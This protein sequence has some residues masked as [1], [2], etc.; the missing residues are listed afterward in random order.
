MKKHVMID[1]ETLS[2]R[3]TAMVLSIGA[4]AFT[5]DGTIHD[6]LEVRPRF[7]DGRHIDPQTVVWWM[8]QSDDARKVFDA[9]ERFG[10]QEVHG[11]LEKFLLSAGSTA[12]GFTGENND[13]PITRFIPPQIW[14]LGPQ[15]DL[16]VLED[17]FG[18]ATGAYPPLWSYR[19]IYDMR[20]LRQFYNREAIK[21]EVQ[22]SALSDAIA[23]AKWTAA[24]I[25]HLKGVSP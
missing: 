25:R 12:E 23:Q 19:Q 6:T 7:V 15:F 1:I 24:A 3:P 14:A 11:L 8:Q 4:C 18:F 9:V 13:T 16:V 22:H 20:T 21:P 2:L 10:R 5:E 17:Y